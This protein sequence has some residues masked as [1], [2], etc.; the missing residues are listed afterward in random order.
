M[1]RRLVRRWLNAKRRRARRVRYLRYLRSP[2]WAEQRRR[3]IARSG[4]RCTSCGV[5]ARSLDVH[6]L[7][8]KRFGRE[9]ASDLTTLCRPCHVRVHGH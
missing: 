6:H 9:R 7:T 4:G 5:R 2:A 8:Y 3:A 1:T